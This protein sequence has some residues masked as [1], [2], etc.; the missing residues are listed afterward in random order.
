[1]MQTLHKSTVAWVTYGYN[2]GYIQ[3]RHWLHTVTTLV[4]YGYNICYIQLQ[5]LYTLHKSTFL[6]SLIWARLLGD[7]SSVDN[8]FFL[9]THF[10]LLI[11]TRRVRAN[12]VYQEYISDRDH[13]HMNATQVRGI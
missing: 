4:T 12:Q 9:V 2:I 8:L 10:I 6:L 13:T 7:S 11:G 3:L 5:Q 1:M